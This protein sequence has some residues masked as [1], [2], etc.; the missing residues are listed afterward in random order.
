M[1]SQSMPNKSRSAVKLKPAEPPGASRE[2]ANTNGMAP[3]AGQRPCRPLA[4]PTSQVTPLAGAIISKRGR[5]LHTDLLRL[6]L[7]WFGLG[8]MH[9]KDSV[10]TLAADRVRVDILGQ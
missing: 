9:R 2:G 7:C 1:P 5:S 10:L 8:D 6:M 4:R 3:D